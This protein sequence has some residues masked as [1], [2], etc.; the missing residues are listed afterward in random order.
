LL[1]SVPEY[2]REEL[3][4]NF[5]KAL[6]GKRINFE[7]VYPQVDG[8]IITFSVSL[9]PVRNA[10]KKVVGVCLTFENITERKKA[11]EVIRKS[12]EQYRDLVNNIS[13]LICTHDL[14]G[15]VLSVNSAA[16]KLTGFRFGLEQPMNIKD[17]VVSN[18]KNEFDDYM[19]GIKKNGF[20]QGLMKIKTLLGETRIW[21][22]NNS[23]KST[24]AGSAI[25]RGY[26]R[27]I[28]EQK[29]AEKELRKSEE[30]FRSFFDQ[31]ADAIFIFD[32][33]GRFLD[34][35]IVST[36]LLGYTKSEFINMT[37]PDVLFKEDLVSVPIRL[38]LL[39][40]GQS[41][42]RQRRFKR[43]DGSTVEV[44]VHSKKMP[45]GNYL[46]VVRDISERKKVDEKLKQLSQVVEQSP[47][48]VVITDLKGNIQYVNQKFISV[49]GYS[50]EELIGKNPRY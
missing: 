15:N 18:G 33:T 19:A 24:G 29:K 28:T 44:E 34:V 11:E 21:E 4:I 25:V 26:A 31:S 3:R 23:L 7:S 22:Y 13:D 47:A 46:G 38:D 14:D 41:L 2:R 35:N 6:Q 50:L 12:E 10:E 45:D 20:G 32:E 49:T 40:A 37:L 8:L 27:D 36:N 43:K 5:E 16:E 42:I 39:V 9:S 30:K 17:L 48:S 1:L